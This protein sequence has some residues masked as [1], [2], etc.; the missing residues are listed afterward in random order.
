[1]EDIWE[2]D[3]MDIPREGMKIGLGEH[4]KEVWMGGGYGKEVCGAYRFG[5]GVPRCGVGT[6]VTALQ[7]SYFFCCFIK[8]YPTVITYLSMTTNPGD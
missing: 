2:D 6:L 4:G 1:M 7:Y 8:L 5:V 3:D